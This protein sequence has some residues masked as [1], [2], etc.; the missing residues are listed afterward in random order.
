MSDKIQWE[1]KRERVVGPRGWFFC[2]TL[3]GLMVVATFG[4]QSQQYA[5]AEVAGEGDFALAQTSTVSLNPEREAVRFNGM[6]TLSRRD[7]SWV[8][9]D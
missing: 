2:L 8:M 1:A 5:H 6:E 3:G 9:D 7:Q 4:Q